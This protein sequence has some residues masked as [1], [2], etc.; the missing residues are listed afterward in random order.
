MNW[1]TYA[2]LYLSEM[3]NE[4]NALEVKKYEDAIR[5]D[6]DNLLNNSYIMDIARDS[7]ISKMQINF[8]QELSPQEAEVL[9]TKYFE[10]L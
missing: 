10:N 5:R 8:N 2:L 1:K 9:I 7:L 6:D 3:K 4:R